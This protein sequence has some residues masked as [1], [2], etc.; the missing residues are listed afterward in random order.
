[1]A[2]TKHTARKSAALALQ[3]AFMA[4]DNSVQKKMAIKHA[5]KQ[6][7]AENR[8]K[9]TL[10]PG[11]KIEGSK[12]SG[13]KSFSSKDCGSKLAFA[14]TAVSKMVG[15][16]AGCG[17]QLTIKPGDKRPLPLASAS[18]SSSSQ[19]QRL[20]VVKPQLPPKKSA[21][22]NIKVHGNDASGLVKKKSRKNRPG[23]IAQREIRQY[24][25]SANLLIQKYPFQ[26]VVREISQEF[27]LEARFE[28]QAVVALQEACEA[29]LVGIF[30]DTN[31]CAV[32]AKRVTIR[33]DDVQ[34][35]RRLRGERV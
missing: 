17:K 28:P 21:P 7:A 4:A 3:A 15:T 13:S 27:K 14:K 24:Q 10:S 5:L 35:A 1:M 25:Q 2:R 12:S 8:G 26:Q 33:P 29:Y 6:L 18:S 23:V 22:P 11:V 19:Q 34:F 20:E 9:G 31:L 30:E 32:K 16:K